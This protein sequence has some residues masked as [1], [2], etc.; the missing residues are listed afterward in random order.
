MKDS[1]MT[2]RAGLIRTLVLCGCITAMVCIAKLVLRKLTNK[3][4]EW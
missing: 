1:P 4:Q 2:D 3:P